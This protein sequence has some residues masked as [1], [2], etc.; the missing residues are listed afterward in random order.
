[1]QRGQGRCAGHVHRHGWPLQTQD[2]SDPPGGEGAAGSEIQVVFAL[3]R[4]HI[5]ILAAAQADIKA[6]AASPEGFGVNSGVLQGVP[7]GFQQYP[8]L[9]VHQPGF[10]GGDTEKP[11][12]EPVNALN[13]STASEDSVPGRRVAGQ[14][15][16]W[17][18]IPAP[19]GYGVA[20]A[21]Q[22]VPEGS[23]VRGA[24]KTAGHADDGYGIAGVADRTFGSERAG[25]FPR[26]G[27]GGSE[28]R[29]HLCSQVAGEGHDVGIVEHRGVGDG[30]FAGQGAVE[31]VPEFHRHEGIHAQVKEP[32]R[33]RGG[34]RQS[35][36]RLQLSLQEGDE[37]VIPG[38]GWTL[39][40]LG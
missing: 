17:S 3:G 24:R 29:L 9:G 11:V 40:Q 33:W 8:L 4:Y 34:R 7:G 32:D 27:S 36:D 31:P 5:P 37:D 28:H 30:V 26:V 21:F 19:V 22:Q 20:A 6:G 25:G 1:M 18:L 38:I 35:E 39:S 2:K 15:L 13:E 12:I 23:Q 10:Q 16:P 14:T